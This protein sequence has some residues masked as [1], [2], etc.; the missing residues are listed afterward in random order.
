MSTVPRAAGSST[1][2]GK[3]LGRCKIG[4][5]IGR[6]ATA[7]VFHATYLPLKRDVAVKI[8]KADA[9]APEARRRFVDEGKALAKLD[10]ENVVRVFDVVEDGGCLLIIMDFVEGRSLLDAIEEDGPLEPA[11]AVETAR[12]IALALDHSHANKILHR[13]VKPGNVI[14]REDGKAVLVDFGN[15]E[16]V[17]EAAD[18]KGTAHYVAPEVFQGKRQDEKSDTYSLGATLFHTLAGEPP[19]R[20]QTLKEILAAHEAG[21]LRAPSQVNPDAGIPREL[22]ALVKRSMAPARGYRFAARDLAAELAGLSSVLTKSSRVRTRRPARGRGAAPSAPGRQHTA[23]YL[24]IGV[25]GL[26]AA[27]LAYAL[28]GGEKA[29]TP[30]PPPKKEDAKREAEPLK[31][32]DDGKGKDS[33]D[34]GFDK[35]AGSRE[36]RDAAAEKAMRDAV[37]YASKHPDQP[38][39]VAEKYAAVASE[40]AELSQGRLAKEEA[41]AWRDRAETGAEKEARE[42]AKKAEADRERQLREEGL[43]KVTDAVATFRFP[44]ALAAFQDVDAPASKIREWKRRGER[45]NALIGFPEMLNEAVQGAPVSAVDVRGTLGKGVEK[46]TGVT[47][48]GFVLKSSTGGERTVPWSEIRP[49]DVTVLGR[50]VLRNSPEPRIMLAAWCWETGQVDEAKKEIDTALLTDRTGTASS[51]VEEMFGLEEER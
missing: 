37:E 8:L 33:L 28:S 43:K 39:A 15:A 21:K 46:V 35:R 22:D 31:A 5:P 4:R 45:L 38:K 42:A 40:Y 12:Q 6:G 2:S 9:T 48:A 16:A 3:T 44:E 50:R 1:Y 13:D 23:L 7:T 14:L 32:I 27:G 29:P 36:A 47:A 30:P 18:R 41:K 19:Y 25:V 20:G 11:A 10:H 24:G 49:V 51:R 34:P 26:I 17:G